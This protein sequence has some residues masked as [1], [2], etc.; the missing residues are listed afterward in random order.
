MK[1]QEFTL[2]SYLEMRSKEELCPKEWPAG[3]AVE[4]R[5]A[6]TPQW[7]FNRFLY[8]TVGQ[9]YL[10][11]DKLSWTD[12]EWEAYAEDPQLTT[13][14][15][16]AE[17]SPVGY[18]ELKNTGADVE[19]VYFGLLPKFIGR[20]Y[21]GAFLTEILEMAWECQ[22]QRI[23]LHTCSHDHPAALANYIS[24]GMRLYRTEKF[25]REG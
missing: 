19:I 11:R 25:P 23:W 18:S 16:Y 5:K 6:I 22:P 9:N 2:V 20:G 21:G 8:Q 10:W 14:V 1:E 12:A 13:F 24:R 7:Q 3:A 17:G 4:V 15:A